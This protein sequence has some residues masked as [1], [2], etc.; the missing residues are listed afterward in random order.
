MK[1]DLDLIRDILL[2]CEKSEERY[3][4]IGTYEWTD[5]DMR[6]RELQSDDWNESEVFHLDLLTQGGFIQ[7][8]VSEHSDIEMFEITWV[9]YDYIEAV[10][11]ENIWRKTKAAVAE[12]GASL[13]IELVKGVAA[14]FAKTQLKKHTGIEL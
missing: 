3:F 6:E 2:K 9:G 7:R 13:T 1:R 8:S 5:H 14:S 4:D 11:N 10:R 12:S